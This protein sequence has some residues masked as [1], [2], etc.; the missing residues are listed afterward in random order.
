VDCNE[1][2]LAD[3]S[4]YVPRACAFAQSGHFTSPSAAANV[5]AKRTVSAEA[6]PGCR[7]GDQFKIGDGVLMRDP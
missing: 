2:D 4:A 3:Y 6:D 7:A 1:G 5:V